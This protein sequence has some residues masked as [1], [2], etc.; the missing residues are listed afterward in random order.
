MA[1][2]LSGTICWKRGKKKQLLGG[3]GRDLSLAI[4][5]S[6]QREKRT[7]RKGENGPSQERDEDRSK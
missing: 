6:F 7:H 1:A 5:S 4:V 2:T 3:K